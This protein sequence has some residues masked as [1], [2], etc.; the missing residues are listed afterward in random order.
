MELFKS[1]MATANNAFDSLQK[2]GRQAA[3]TAEAN[4]AAVTGSMTKAPAKAKRA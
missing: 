2:A 4:Y 3:E 1:A